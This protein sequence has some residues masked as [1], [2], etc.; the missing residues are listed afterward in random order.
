MPCT[1]G[2]QTG[3]TV[4]EQAT[5]SGTRRHAPPGAVDSR[6]DVTALRSGFEDVMQAIPVPGD[7]RRTATIGGVNDRSHIEGVDPLT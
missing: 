7:V 1:S 6:G 2:Q 4:D 3:E 5:A